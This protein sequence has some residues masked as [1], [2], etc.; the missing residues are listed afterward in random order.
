V[1][2][3]CIAQWSVITGLAKEQLMADTAFDQNLHKYATL[4]V[5]V[6]VN[7][8]PGDLL[9]V[10]V[11]LTDDPAIRKL[12]HYIVEI[13]YQAGAKY[14]DVNWNDEVE[15]KLRV[16]HAPDGT[17]DYVPSWRTQA[18]ETYAAERVSRLVINANN[19]LLLAGLDPERVAT[20]QRARQ[21]AT[22]HLFPILFDENI[23]SLTAVPV[24]EWADL[25]FP[26]AAKKSDFTYCGMLFFEQHAS[27]RMTP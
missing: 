24:Q 21:A 15:A 8:R 18:I 20:M 19:P 12:V 2:G 23:W 27:T 17:L 13:A 6:G 5:K 22:A 7:L 14:V 11:S 4:L 3:W 16:L 1:L 10:T 25:V 9:H 26:D